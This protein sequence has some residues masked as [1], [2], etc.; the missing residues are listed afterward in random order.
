MTQSRGESGAPLEE[1]DIC[2]DFRLT[3]PPG[4]RVATLAGQRS[5]AALAG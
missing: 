3:G 1:T 2:G 5:V 4:Q